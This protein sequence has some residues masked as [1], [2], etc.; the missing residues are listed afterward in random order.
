MIACL[1]CLVWVLLVYD[2]E[3]VLSFAGCLGL[4]VVRLFWFCL[5]DLLFCFLSIAVACADSTWCVGV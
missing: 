5:S 4:V 2:D 3:F 1:V